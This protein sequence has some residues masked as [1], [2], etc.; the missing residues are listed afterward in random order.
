MHRPTKRIVS[1]ALG[2]VLVAGCGGSATSGSLP[3]TRLDYNEAIVRS[4]NEQLLLNL[5]RLRY[6]HAPQFFEV[7]AVTTQSSVT[8]GGNFGIGGNLGNNLVDNT[9]FTPFVTPSLG[10][11]VQV[12]DR[13]TV[14]YQPL[15]GEAFAQRMVRPIRPETLLLLVDVGWRIDRLLACCVQRINGVGAPALSSHD[16]RFGNP[17]FPSSTSCRCS[18]RSS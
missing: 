6:L 12:E 4:S 7:T 10:G 16:E 11:S 17:R 15:Q 3:S 14:S 18:R 9:I 2:L 13:P 5:V 8:Q 1:I